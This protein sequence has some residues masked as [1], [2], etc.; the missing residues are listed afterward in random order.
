MKLVAQIRDRKTGKVLY[1][2]DV[3]FPDEEVS[4]VIR[5][6][7]ILDAEHRLLEQT[8]KVTWEKK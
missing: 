5:A 8:L 7:S 3:E 4:D 6:A 1:T 2:C